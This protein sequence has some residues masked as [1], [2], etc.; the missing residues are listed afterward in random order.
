METGIFFAGS[1]GMREYKE[2]QEYCQGAG[3]P[4][5]EARSRAIQ[6]RNIPAAFGTKDLEAI[7]A[8]ANDHESPRAQVS[9]DRDGVYIG[10]LH[11]YH[12]RDMAASLREYFKNEL[13]TV[14]ET[15]PPKNGEVVF[16]TTEAD[17]GTWI[18]TFA[19]AYCST[20][21]RVKKHFHGGGSTENPPYYGL[22]E[23]HCP[24]SRVYELRPASDCD[25]GR[26]GI[27]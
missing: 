13:G 8:M 27:E 23:S 1:C 7:Q 26:S 18:H 2:Y 22:R 3:R 5:I 15:P 16:V 25:E 10:F 4:F 20:K 19:C 24:P 21:R 12:V 17:R 9:E 11:P 6:V 14:W